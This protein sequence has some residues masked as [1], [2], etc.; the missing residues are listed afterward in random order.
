MLCVISLLGLAGM[1]FAAATMRESDSVRA[2][3]LLVPLIPVG[4]V[5]LVAALF[6]RR[7]GIG[8][9]LGVPLGCGCATWVA[10]VVAMFVFF[11][12]IWPSL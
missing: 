9:A 5:A 7:K 4:L 6:T 8:I 12:L 1:I 11:A 2:S 3:Y 10:G